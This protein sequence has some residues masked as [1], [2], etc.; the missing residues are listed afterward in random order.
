MESKSFHQLVERECTIPLWCGVCKRYQVEGCTKQEEGAAGRAGKK[1]AKKKA[2]V[3]AST[4]HK[5]HQNTLEE[6]LSS[7]M[8]RILALVQGAR[9]MVQK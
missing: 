1:Y 8:L 2:M 7:G 4:A 9:R 5:L 3:E 6:K